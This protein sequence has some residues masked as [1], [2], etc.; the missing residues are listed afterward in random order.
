MKS[1]PALTLA[2]I[3]LGAGSFASAALINVNFNGG[4]D[5]P[6][7]STLAGPAGGLGTT[8][9]SV[10]TVNTGLLN[11]STGASTTVSIATNYSDIKLGQ[12]TSGTLPVFRSFMDVFSRPNTNTVTFNGLES[13]GIYDIWILSYRDIT[14]AST[15]ERNVGTWTTSNTTTSPSSQSVNSQTG[16]PDGTTFQEG[17]NYVLF[18]NVE[19]TVGGVISFTAAGNGAGFPQDDNSR[20]VHLNGLQINQVP[21]PSSLLLI[22]FG[23]FLGL[24]RRR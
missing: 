4:G 16:S 14:T 17:Y 22:A 5:S 24:R 2:A 3:A 7:E 12:Q 19:A 21:E 8:W 18:E 1:K 11:D 6:V 10:A 23:G 13:G 20:R 15:T 9:N